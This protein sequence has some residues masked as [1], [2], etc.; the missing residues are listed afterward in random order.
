[1]NDLATRFWV[2]QRKYIE[3]LDKAPVLLRRW[4]EGHSVIRLDVPL[5]TLATC[6]FYFDAKVDIPVLWL[7]TIAC[8]ALRDQLWCIPGVYINQSSVTFS[9]IPATL[10]MQWQLYSELSVAT[11]L[12][13]TEAML[14]ERNAVL[15]VRV[16]ELETKLENEFQFK[17]PKTSVPPPSVAVD[18]FALLIGKRFDAEDAIT[19][20]RR[21]QSEFVGR[22]RVLDSA[23]KDML[24][25]HA[26]QRRADAKQSRLSLALATEEISRLNVMVERL[27]SR[28]TNADK[29]SLV[30]TYPI[31]PR[32]AL[33]LAGFWDVAPNDLLR[34]TPHLV[35]RFERDGG[36]VIRQ[37]NLQVCFPAKDQ[38]ILIN[39]VVEVMAEHLPQYIRAHLPGEFF[40]IVFFIFPHPHSECCLGLFA[41][42]AAAQTTQSSSAP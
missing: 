39:V 2:L 22:K 40:S 28:S 36:G 41:S 35:A 8:C 1:M 29:L 32:R 7:R 9:N 6:L 10:G 16:L 33:V 31:V 15:A 24:R 11:Q 5:E 4:L 12:P 37:S 25:T 3:F 21:V 14:R 38:A 20:L 34:V 19:L 13:E 26:E 23:C 30:D 17:M 27:H 42:V 18:T